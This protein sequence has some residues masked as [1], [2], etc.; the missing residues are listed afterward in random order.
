MVV[1][2]RVQIVESTIQH[3]YH[4]ALRLSEL[5]RGV[6]LSPSRLR[7]LFKQHIGQTL[8]QY[9]R[10]IRLQQAK[11]L[12]ETTHLRVKEVMAR[13]GINDDSHFTRDFKRVFR[14][15]PSKYRTR[16]LCHELELRDSN[17]CQQIATSAKS[18]RLTDHSLPKKIFARNNLLLLVLLWSFTH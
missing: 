14:F 9:L 4:R 5:A 11:F 7:H 1:D 8:A 2:V 3:E 6:N 10:H 13:V 18:S 15:A 16:Y 12:L 17:S